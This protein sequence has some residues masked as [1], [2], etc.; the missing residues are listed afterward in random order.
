M[1]LAITVALP[2]STG[3]IGQGIDIAKPSICLVWNAANAVGG[4]IGEIRKSAGAMPA[5]FASISA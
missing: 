5:R 4:A 3:P 1:P 2:S